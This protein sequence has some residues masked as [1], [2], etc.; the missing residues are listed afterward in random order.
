MV[1]EEKS[2]E[3]VDGRRTDDGRT[4]EPSHPKSFPGALG[5]GELK[6][7]KHGGVPYYFKVDNGFTL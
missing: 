3:R 5:S 1:S 4:T 6:S 7:E 2:F